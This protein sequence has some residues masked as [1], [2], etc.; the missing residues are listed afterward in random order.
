MNQLWRE[1]LAL[2]QASDAG[3]RPSEGKLLRPALCLLAAGTLDES[4][5]DRYASLAAA[6]EVIHMASL[7]HDDV[8]DHAP[9]RRGQDSLNARW[10]NHTAILCGDYLVARGIELINAYE[11][12]ALNAAALEAV[13]SM[14]AGELRFFGRDPDTAPESDCIAL[15]ESKTASLFAA[16]CCAPALLIAPD[17]GGALRSFG[18]NLGIAFQLVD[19]LL[20]ITQPADTLGKPACGD[21]VEGKHTLP[22]FLLRQAM[23]QSER[24]RLASLRG[25]NASEADCRWLQER[26]AR[27]GVDVAVGKRARH[28]MDQGLRSLDALP[29]SPCRDAMTALAEFVLRR[30]A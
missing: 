1:S 4:A 14:A 13:R 11:S 2:T 29:A 30:R 5:L 26:V 19:D 3:E 17:H 15:A 28:Y 7:A 24:D 10:N 6:Y 18:V 25:A 20:D 8:V 21:V 27:L 9:L 12:S 23:T 22:L 16:A